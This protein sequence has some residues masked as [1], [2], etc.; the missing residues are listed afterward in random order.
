V[1]TMLYVL[2]RSSGRAVKYL[3]SKIVN[4]ARGE[5]VEP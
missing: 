4:S 1:K 3:I 2:R 5:L